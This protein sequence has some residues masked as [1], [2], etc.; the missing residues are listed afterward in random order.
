MSVNNVRQFS[1]FKLDKPLGLD[2][3]IE[4]IWMIWIKCASLICSQRT[5]RS[6]CDFFFVCSRMKYIWTGHM[7]VVAAYGVCGKE[8]WTLLLSALQCNSKILVWLQKKKKTIT[9]F[10]KVAQMSKKKKKTQINIKCAA[11]RIEMKVWRLVLR[12]TSPSLP[13]PRL[14]H[15]VPCGVH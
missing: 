10:S 6:W 14:G 11:H 12:T 13:L 5:L 9:T 7:C 3:M 2:F 8:S 1:S 15:H 4:L